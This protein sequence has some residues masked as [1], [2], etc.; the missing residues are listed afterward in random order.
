MTVVLQGTASRFTYLFL[1]WSSR[2]KGLACGGGGG[3]RETRDLVALRQTDQ[4]AQ[5]DE[6]QQLQ[7]ANSGLS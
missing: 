4:L 7:I 3:A 1:V 2:S 6:S 5:R